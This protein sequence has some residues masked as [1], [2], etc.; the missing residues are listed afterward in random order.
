LPLSVIFLRLLTDFYETLFMIFLHD[1]LILIPRETML[2]NLIDFLY[3]LHLVRLGGV[4]VSVIA[5]GPR[6]C[7]FEPFQ[8]D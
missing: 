3:N 4:V 7:G 6:G 8:G 2:E 1:K 5:A